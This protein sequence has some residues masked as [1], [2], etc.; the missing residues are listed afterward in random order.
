MFQSFTGNSRKPRHVNLSGQNSS[1]RKGLSSNQ[2]PNAATPGGQAAIA[3]AQAQRLQRGHERD[4]LNASRLL[5]RSWRGHSSRQRIRK[6]WRGEWD[7]HELART[8]PQ[9]SGVESLV[10]ITPDNGKGGQAYGSAGE[11]YVQMRL[12]LHFLDIKLE[13]DRARLAYFGRALQRT[14]EVVP[15]IAT[16]DAWTLQLYRLSKLT[17]EALHA[18]ARGSKSMN[19]GQSE[20]LLFLLLFVSRL[21]PKYMARNAKRYYSALA[22]LLA[23]HNRLPGVFGEQMGEAVLALLTPI[24]AETMTA[25]VG[26]GT[27][28]LTAPEMLA[29][30]SADRLVAPKLNYKML[31]AA[32]NHTMEEDH[33]TKTRILS[34]NG[35]SLWLLAHL[36]F[37][38]RYSL[39][40]TGSFHVPQETDY[41]RILSALLAAQG[42]EI[43][44]RIDIRDEPMDDSSKRR[45]GQKEALSSAPLPSFV[46]E[47]ILTLIK[48]DSIVRMMSQ[49]QLS[50]SCEDR[51]G[52]DSAQALATYAL[53]LTRVFPGQRADEIRMWLYDGSANL[54]TTAGTSTI[55][56][57]WHYSRSTAVFQKISK[58]HHNAI[59]LLRPFL[60]IDKS[61]S[62]QA[63]KSIQQEWRTLLLFLELYSFA[64]RNMDDEGFLAG[65]QFGTDGSTDWGAKIRES[66]LP[67]T[68]VRDLVTFLKNLAFALY[69]NSRDLQEG[70]ALEQSAGL[71]AYFG[72][73]VQGPAK[74][75]TVRSADTS[76]GSARIQLR[77]LVTGILR[78]IHQRE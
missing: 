5:Q 61:M 12:L 18:V 17:V 28:L 7:Q 23:Q 11:C 27:E 36:I 30:I 8:S 44:H 20:S 70:D 2:T 16:G 47:Q 21:I 72:T 63:L 68:E 64:I 35:R 33:T 13:M 34:H 1:T 9:R 41:I 48:K 56:Y 78:S 24:T 49:I 60:G 75:V 59:P 57:F 40:A 77:D 46:R 6:T 76:Q 4:R 32:L 29:H 37:L 50:K 62:R 25:Y 45:N 71:G 55:T 38:H 58:D 39:G 73:T 66:S 69:W 31:T 14:L 65:G 74:G 67:L 53:T 3:Q 26:F 43:S 15:S 51:I 22:R 19:T 42:D 10:E 54:K 52:S